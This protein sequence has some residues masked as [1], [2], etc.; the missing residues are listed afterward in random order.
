MFIWVFHLRCEVLAIFF[1]PAFSILQL[2]IYT[3]TFLF[4]Y[5]LFAWLP[6]LATLAW[7]AA[8]AIGLFASFSTLAFDSSCIYIPQA[9]I[10]F[11]LIRIF[12]NFLQLRQYPLPTVP[13]TAAAAVAKTEKF[14]VSALSW[15]TACHAANRLTDLPTDC[16]RSSWWALAWCGRLSFHFI[17]YG[18]VWCSRIASDWFWRCQQSLSVSTSACRPTY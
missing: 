13:V 2:R 16:E 10:R 8:N 1:V 17:C 9:G 6:L 12:Y 7:N 11:R 5:A 3:Y 18:L 14:K 4:I 15:L